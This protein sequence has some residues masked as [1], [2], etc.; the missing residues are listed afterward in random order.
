MIAHEIGDIITH[1]E[2]VKKM[3]GG[4]EYYQGSGEYKE[5]EDTSGEGEGGG[6]GRD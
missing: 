4:G 5:N 1:E 2:S 6:V 3:R